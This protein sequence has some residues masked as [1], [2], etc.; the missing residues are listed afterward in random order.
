MDRDKGIYR[1]Y[2]VRLWQVKGAEAAP[3]RA[4]LESPLTGEYHGFAS[5]KA[6]FE[7]LEG[8]T[9]G[10]GSASH[11]QALEKP[12]AGAKIEQ[13]EQEKSA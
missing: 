13:G 3:W 2:L 12:D 4:S 5:L 9:G 10:S 6:L 1:S 8:Q 11:V 7:F